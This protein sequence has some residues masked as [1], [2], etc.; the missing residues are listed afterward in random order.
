MSIVHQG[1]KL[2]RGGLLLSAVLSG[3]FPTSSFSAP[4]PINVVEFADFTCPHCLQTEPSVPDL[5][6]QVQ[7]TGGVMRVAPVGPVLDGVPARSI[8]VYYAILTATNNNPSIARLVEAAMFKGYANGAMMDSDDGVISWL[9]NN[10][11]TGIDWSAVQ[12][13]IPSAEQRFYKAYR[14]AKSLHVTSLPTFVVM[15]GLSGQ[16]QDVIRW[17]GSANDVV[18]QT[19]A[20]INKSQEKK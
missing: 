5:S 19:Q 7:K 8:I 4:V 18:T 20:A 12:Q 1:K 13:D 10:I 15:N 2:I 6:D 17:K 14:L 16:I 9:S 3:F 11:A